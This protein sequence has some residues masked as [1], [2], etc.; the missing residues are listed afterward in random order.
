LPEQ[1]IIGPE[2]EHI[3]FAVDPFHKACLLGG[4][5]EIG[6]TLQKAHA[7]EAFET[8]QRASQPWLYR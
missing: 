6:L 3:G 1:R 4:L 2:G 5:D 7:I 8:R